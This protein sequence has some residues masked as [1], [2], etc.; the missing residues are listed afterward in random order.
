[1]VLKMEEG[2]E[3]KNLMLKM[4]IAKALTTRLDLQAFRRERKAQK[5]CYT[6]WSK[7]SVR[8]LEKKHSLL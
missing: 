6:L 1:M 8:T 5:M 3:L 4:E 2:S 7:L